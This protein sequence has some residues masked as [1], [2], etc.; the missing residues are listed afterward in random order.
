MGCHNRACL[1]L[2]W[3]GLDDEQMVV[4]DTRDLNF[5]SSKNFEPRT[6]NH[7]LSPL[8][9]SLTRRLSCWLW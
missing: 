2:R 9:A 5:L 4:R 6:S 3:V 7:C 8:S 1:S